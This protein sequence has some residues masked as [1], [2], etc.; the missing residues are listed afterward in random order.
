MRKSSAYARKI[1]RFGKTYNG[2]EWLNVI[3]K[4]RP[5]DEE[6]IPGAIA[7]E[8]SFAA[9]RKAIV[10][11]RTSFEA[12]KVGNGSERAWDFLAHATGITKVRSIQI[13]GDGNEM[14]E[15]LHIADAALMKVKNRYLKW[16]KWELLPAEV[17]DI[18]YALDLYEEVATNSSPAQMTEAM[19]VREQILD[20]QR[21]PA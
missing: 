16:G 15:P 14:L 7:T 18:A 9:V 17:Q 3:T 4:C 21:E 19:K 10:D 12:I 5:Y 1:R 20:K 13:A 11:V 6:L 8:P 2:A